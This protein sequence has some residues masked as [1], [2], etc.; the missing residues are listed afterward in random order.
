MR[1]HALLLSALL[2][3]AATAAAQ[4]QT[5]MRGGARRMEL[6]FKDITLT[7]AQQAKVDSIQA[8]YRSERPSFTPG[9]PP[10]SATREKI[11]ALFQRERDDLRAVLTP[12]QQKT[13]DRNV[14][15]MRQ[16]RP[17]GA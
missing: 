3:L 7:P 9:A 5:P 2:A 12:D 1:L 4:A 10:D 11:R 16:R 17:G 13:F 14:E 6:L 8:R 15:E